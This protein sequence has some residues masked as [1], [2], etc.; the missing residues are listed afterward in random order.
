MLLTDHTCHQMKNTTRSINFHGGVEKQDPNISIPDTWAD[1]S[2]RNIQDSQ[3]KRRRLILML[4][5]IGLISLGRDFRCK[6][7]LAAPE[8]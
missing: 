4:S 1:N 2:N 3:G 6:V 7:S 5:D 8:G